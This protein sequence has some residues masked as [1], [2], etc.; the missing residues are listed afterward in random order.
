VDVDGFRETG[1][2]GLNLAMEDFD[3]TSVTTTLGGKISRVINTDWAVLVPQLRFEWEHEYDNDATRLL[4]RFAA[5]PTRT[6][7]GIETD[8]P[9]RDYFRLGLGVSAVFPYG[10]SGFVNYN[11][12]LDKQDW[13][14][15]LIDV[16]AR[17][18]F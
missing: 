18:E 5:D 1:A 7:F 11:T 3:A 16:G 9:D 10:W 14:D 12:V 13:T 15:H 17:W 8:D 4:A 2:G 6:A